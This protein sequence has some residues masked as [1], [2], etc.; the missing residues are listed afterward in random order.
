MN[1]AKVE[2]LLFPVFYGNNEGKGVEV[3]ESLRVQKSKSSA[4]LWDFGLWARTLDLR[5]VELFPSTIVYIY[6]LSKLPALWKPS[7]SSTRKS[8]N[9]LCRFKAITRNYRNT[10]AKCRKLFQWGQ[11]AY[12]P[13]NITSLLWVFQKKLIEGY[14]GSHGDM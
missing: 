8:C 4:P 2:Q 5:L 12:R 7:M 13:A 14:A 3:Q 6:S 1:P 11:P 9:W 10:W